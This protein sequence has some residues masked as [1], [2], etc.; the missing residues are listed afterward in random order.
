MR[1]VRTQARDRS[2]TIGLPDGGG[3]M[4]L[5]IKGL[6]KLV[7]QKAS[8]RRSRR[9][10]ASQANSGRGEDLLPSHFVV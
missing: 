10:Y 5:G 7:L 4:G 9:D 3:S 8:G 6:A 1:F 2:E